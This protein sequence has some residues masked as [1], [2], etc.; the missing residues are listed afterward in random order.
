MSNEN[1]LVVF[2]AVPAVTQTDGRP[3][4]ARGVVDQVQKAVHLGVEQ[5]ETN[6]ATFMGNIA[7]ILDSAQAVAGSYHVERVEVEAMVSADGKVGLAGSSVGVSGKSSLKLILVRSQS[8][9][10]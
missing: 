8:G 9:G 1:T 3:M 7:R 2:D 5:L 10:Q 6:F 4:Q